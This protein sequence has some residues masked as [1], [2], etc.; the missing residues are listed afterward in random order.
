MGNEEIIE[1]ALNDNNYLNTFGI[2][3]CTDKNC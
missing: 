2:F 1:T 3:E